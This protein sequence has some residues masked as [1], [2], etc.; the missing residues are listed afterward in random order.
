MALSYLYLLRCVYTSVGI[1][2]PCCIGLNFKHRLDLL[3]IV[4][5]YQ[6]NDATSLVVSSRRFMKRVNILLTQPIL[7]LFPRNLI[8]SFFFDRLVHS[9]TCRLIWVEKSAR[10]CFYHRKILSFEQW[11]MTPATG[12]YAANAVESAL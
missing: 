2:I 11:H 4:Q 12:Q 6:N 9:K 1:Y 10:Q 8:L 7:N 3:E 5:Q